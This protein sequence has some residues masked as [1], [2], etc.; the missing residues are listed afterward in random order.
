EAT[1]STY[2]IG[3]YLGIVTNANYTLSVE[4][5]SIT[6][7]T[8]DP[9]ATDAGTQIYTNQSGI[10]GDYYFAITTLGTA[11]GV[12]RT[13]LNVQSG[14]A[15]VYLS[16]GTLPTTASYGYGSA[17]VGSDGFVLAQG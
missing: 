8:W 7:L 6:T 4:L 2:F 16:L 14:E 3:V 5:A 17:R 11:D 13:A 12:W 9:G 15:D 1:N 10:G